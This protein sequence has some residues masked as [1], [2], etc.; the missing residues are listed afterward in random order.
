[1]ATT[2]V[3]P[4]A[5]STSVLV[6]PWLPAARSVQSAE[7]SPRPGRPKRMT[8]HPVPLRPPPTSSHVTVTAPRVLFEES[9]SSARVLTMNLSSLDE[10]SSVVTETPVPDLPT[11]VVK[12]T[13]VQGARRVA[14]AIAKKPWR[15]LI[16]AAPIEVMLM[17]VLFFFVLGGIL[18][19]CLAAY[20]TR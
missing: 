18:A 10:V 1:M 9:S 5:D 19:M 13:H 20:L 2:R 17:F 4:R 15:G 3:L 7:K 8:H 12:E 14:R 11:R 6:A 16:P